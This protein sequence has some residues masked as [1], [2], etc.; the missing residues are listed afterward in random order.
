MRERE[1]DSEQHRSSFRQRAGGGPRGRHRRVTALA[2]LRD[3]AKQ[4]T[5]AA[6]LRVPAKSCSRGEKTAQ[7]P[8]SHCFWG[9]GRGGL[10]ERGVERAGR[11][12]QPGNEKEFTLLK[13]FHRKTDLFFF[14]PLFWWI[15]SKTHCRYIFFLPAKNNFLFSVE[16][17]GK[18]V[19]ALNGPL[20]TRQKNLRSSA[21]MESSPCD[22]CDAS[23]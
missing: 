17:G 2:E 22:R 9:G 6:E 5:G 10:V 1:R 13:N 11:E 14:P 8:G 3:H 15:T 23:V 19:G 16:E 18:G 12:T 21:E 4:S 20:S 7:Q